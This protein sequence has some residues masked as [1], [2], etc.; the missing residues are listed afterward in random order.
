MID[1]YNTETNQLIGSITDTD[2]QVLVDC[3]EE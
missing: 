2:L 3:L 1:L